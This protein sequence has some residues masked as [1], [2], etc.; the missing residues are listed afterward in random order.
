MFLLVTFCKQCKPFYHKAIE[1]LSHDANG[2]QGGS[3]P[4]GSWHVAYS[5]SRPLQA[6]PRRDHAVCP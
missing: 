5:S 3:L 1:G 4:R 2:R 6:K